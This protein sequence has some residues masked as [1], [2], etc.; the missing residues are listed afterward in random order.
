MIPLFSA[1]QVREADNFAVKKL[2]IPGITLMENASRSIFLKIL[3]NFSGLDNSQTISILCGKGNN[4]G[5]GFALAR[6]FI[7]YGYKVLA[8]SFVKEKELKGDALTNLEALKNLIKIENGSSL[9]LYKDIKDIA[10]IKDS[11]LIVDALLGTGTKGELREPYLSVLRKINQLNVLRVAVDL[12]S[13]LDLDNSSGKLIFDAHLTITLGELKTGLFYGQ[14]YIKS[15]IVEKG[16][17][18]IGQ[19]YFNGLE[20]NDY[21]IEP[22]D[23]FFGIPAKELN[24]HKYSSG[25]VF[26]IAGSG[27]LPGAA[28]LTANTVL[29]AGGGASV[30]A[31]PQ[32]IKQTAQQKLESAVVHPYKDAQTEFLSSENIAELNEKI[33]WTDVIAIGPG[34]GRED[35]TSE[36]VRKIIKKNPAKKFIIDADAVFALK[37]GQYKN[38][39]LKNKILTPHHK[40]FA[41]LLGIALEELNNKLLG[42]GKN[43]AV[44]TSAYLVL[45]GAPTIIFTPKGEAI[46]NSTG[47]PGMATFG[48][49][50]V[51]TGAIA[52]F[53]SNSFS[54]EQA[55]IS[56]VYIHSLSADLLLEENS[57]L[58][59]T[60][61]AIMNNIPFTIKFLEDTFV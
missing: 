11:H 16:Y 23:A 1:Q 24:S 52:A 20:V 45:K 3:E 22:E 10:K 7:N 47:N 29:K 28:C 53:V 30:L 60:A 2:K 26:T 38:L 44:E 18:G 19:E 43:F 9:Y 61:D 14:G 55:L 5:D 40:E 49:G 58:G 39:N 4:G 27:H 36:A 48:T 56:A 13:G 57:E 8:L 6:H 12:P 46:I 21:L 15:G 37:D 32:S 51:L 50:D 42:Y 54:L 41:D 34:L 17:I 33:K 25:K 59:I 35:S 31:F